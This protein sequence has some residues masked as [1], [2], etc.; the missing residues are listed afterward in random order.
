MATKVNPKVA[1]SHGAGIDLKNSH[2]GNPSLDSVK[3][4]VSSQLTNLDQ[5]RAAPSKIEKEVTHE[6]RDS[7]NEQTSETDSDVESCSQRTEECFN[8]AAKQPIGNSN[9][10]QF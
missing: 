5:G 3:K 4:A 10:W 2:R 7:D 6:K 9:H 1:A 8:T